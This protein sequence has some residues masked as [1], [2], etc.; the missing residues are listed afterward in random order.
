MEIWTLKAKA[1]HR[2]KLGHP[3]VFADEVE[4]IPVRSRAGGPV[5]LRDHRGE[6]VAVGYG[7]PESPIVFRAM[8]FSSSEKNMV[9]PE[10]VLQRLLECW[11]QRRRLGF[12]GSFRLAFGEADFLPGLVVDYYLVEQRGQRGQVFAVQVLTQGMALLLS[13]ADEIFA[14]LV[15]LAQSEG[16]TELGWENSAVVL[17]ND[18]AARKKEG[19]EEEFPRFIKSV[20]N[21]DY[22]RVDILINAAWD[23]GLVP[24]GCDLFQGQKTGFFLDQTWNIKIF[25][26]LVRNHFRGQ[27]RVRVLDLC[28]YVGHWSSQVARVFRQEGVATE[29]HQV[30]VS[31]TALDFAR[32]N[33]ERQ[34]AIVYS[35]QMDVMEGLGKFSDREFDIV[36]A[37]PPA[38]V[39]A[40]KDL[41]GGMSA[42][43][44]L[45][46][47]AFR[48]VRPRGFVVSCSCSGLFLEEM[49]VEALRKAI[50]RTKR[51]VKCVARGGHAPDHPTLVSFPEG[52]YLKMFVH[53]AVDGAT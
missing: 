9:S 11:R 5:E 14:E 49:L 8:S 19:L 1:E 10:G 7:N 48:L 41:A 6:F 43:V 44:K 51:R 37:D 29:A 2:V 35:H 20:R 36:I 53:Q 42:Y 15:R 47:Q 52:I 18:T 39:K 22:E 33:A 25:T 16:L 4:S 46:H 31:A 17:R 13:R 26:G 12:T 27:D 21:F 23:E 24:M 34:G 45:N 28:S 32:R 30:D 40:K 3:W 38:F 50:Q